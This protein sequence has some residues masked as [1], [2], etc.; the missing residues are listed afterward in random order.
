V[1][2]VA[3][4]QGS[5]QTVLRAFQSKVTTVNCLLTTGQSLRPGGTGLGFSSGSLFTDSIDC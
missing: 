2:D 5:R 4:V 1:G 3:A